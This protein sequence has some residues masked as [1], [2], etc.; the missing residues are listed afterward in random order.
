MTN[1]IVIVKRGPLII[2]GPNITQ[3]QSNLNDAKFLESVQRTAAFHAG[4]SEVI[5]KGRK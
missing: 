1:K 2:F 4:L 3:V 5:K